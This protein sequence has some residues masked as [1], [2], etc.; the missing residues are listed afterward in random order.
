[1]K[2]KICGLKSEEDILLAN[3]HMPDFIGFVFYPPSKRYISYH[4]AVDLKKILDNRIQVVGVFV[5]E[6]IKRIEEICKK[7]V[8]DFIQLHG[9]EDETYLI[10][11]KELVRKPVIK[12]VRVKN[13]NQILQAEK[14]S[15]EYLLLDTYLSHTMG[16][17]GVAFDHSMIP[18]LHKPYFLAGGIHA[19]NIQ[20]AVTECAPFAVD[21]SSGCEVN[22]CKD[23]D[24][25]K[26]IIALARR[27]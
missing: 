22:G 2:I 17:S 26:E 27:L 4:R 9:D 11:L 12:A 14:L 18:K 6:D 7:G 5:N 3:Q 20:K 15:C 8:I 19:G 23:E 1:M 16:G 10:K 13:K 25:F 24:K 21:V